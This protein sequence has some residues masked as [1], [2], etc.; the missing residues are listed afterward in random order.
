MKKLFS[1]LLIAIGI[2]C[3]L[4]QETDA[5]IVKQVTLSKASLSSTDTSY[6]NITPDNTYVSV[7]FHGNKTSGTVAGKIYVLGL[8]LNGSGYDKL[9]SLAITNVTTDQWKLYP[10]RYKDYKTYQIQF[11]S[12]GGIWV[13][14][15]FTLRRSAN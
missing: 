12:T 10:F 9:D 2:L 5:Q 6:I 7:E 4:P 15:A 13:P 8:A 14:T 11:L 3:V 1:L